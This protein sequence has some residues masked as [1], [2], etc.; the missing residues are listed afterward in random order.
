MVG[1]GLSVPR[2]GLLGRSDVKQT[3]WDSF[4]RGSGKSR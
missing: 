1:W 3:L 4:P 2:V